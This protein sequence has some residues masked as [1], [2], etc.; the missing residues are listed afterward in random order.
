MTNAFR[1]KQPK[2]PATEKT[3]AK[4]HKQDYETRVKKGE[5]Y[6]EA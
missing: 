2:L 4:K 6:D 1:K 5:Y 3:R